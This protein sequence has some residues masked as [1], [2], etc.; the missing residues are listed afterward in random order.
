MSEGWRGE[1]GRGSRGIWGED[2]GNADY[3]ITVQPSQQHFA[4]CVKG[5]ESGL[6]TRDFWNK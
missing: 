2:E 1:R 5:V 3:G 6:G 4:P